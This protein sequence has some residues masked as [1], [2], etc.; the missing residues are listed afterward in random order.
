[1][2]R[3]DSLGRIVIPKEL[4]E[5]YELTEGSDIC[6]EDSGNGVL[7]KASGELCLMCKCKIQK[8]SP[9]FLC[10]KCIA[11]VKEYGNS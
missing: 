9:F 11:A 5:K 1:M 4:R 6:F 8:N 7:V 2:R 10:E 3:V